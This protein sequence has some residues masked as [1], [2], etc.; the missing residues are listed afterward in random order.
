[1]LSIRTWVLFQLLFSVSVWAGIPLDIVFDID[2]TIVTLIHEGVNGD[3]L[4]DPR[5]PQQNTVTVSFNRPELDGN[6]KPVVD[7]K[8]QKVFH[9]ATER[10]RYYEGLTDLMKELKRL[11]DSGMI[12]VSFFSGGTAERNSALLDSIKLKDGTSLKSL[13]GTRIYGRDRMLVTGLGPEHR[14][15]ERFKKDLQII[16][17]NLE[18]VILVDDIKEFVPSSQKEHLLWIGE[19]FPYPERARDSPVT[20]NEDLLFRE[21]NKYQ[22]ISSKL[23]EA[24]ARRLKEKTPLSK[25]ISEMTLGGERT[26]FT[27]GEEKLYF[28]TPHAHCSSQ[29]MKHLLKDLRAP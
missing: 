8:G 15:R 24:I 4:A 17:P 20:F 2:Q 28:A 27:P 18:D 5:N 9:K 12:R 19:D 29:M 23:R 16:N 11:Q 3:L 7:S 1:M 26:P 25:I 14:V 10:Y 6:N 13:A 22:W 21:K